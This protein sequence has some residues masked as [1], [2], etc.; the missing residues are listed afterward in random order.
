MA[1]GGL[2]D[3]GAFLATH[4]GATRELVLEYSRSRSPGHVVVNF[5]IGVA[6]WHRFFR[7]NAVSRSSCVISYAIPT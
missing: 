4:H 6:H 7:G 2:L 5:K 3:T 1:T